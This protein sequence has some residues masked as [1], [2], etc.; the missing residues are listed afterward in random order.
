MQELVYGPPEAQ[1]LIRDR[2][3][4]AVIRDAS[5][6]IHTERFEVELEVDEN[7]FYPFVIREGFAECCLTFCMMMRME[8]EQPK[9]WRWIE[10]AKEVVDATH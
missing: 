5:D 3:P 7:E 10:M 6:R 8:E 9:V 1:G 4:N 2:W